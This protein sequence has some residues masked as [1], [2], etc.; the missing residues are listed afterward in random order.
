M[1]VGKSDQIFQVTL[2]QTIKEWRQAKQMTLTVLAEASGPPI[3]KG[4]ISQLEHS[5]IRQPHDEHLIRIACALGIEAT[6]LWNR[7]LPSKENLSQ[8]N[9]PMNRADILREILL[10]LEKTRQKVAELLH[11]E[12]VVE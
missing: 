4:Y 7:D 6:Q 12:H 1:S 3:T 10:D 8:K 9:Q 2:G 11:R 5:K